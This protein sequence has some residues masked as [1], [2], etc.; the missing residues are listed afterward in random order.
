MRNSSTSVREQILQAIL[1]AITPVAT[2]WG[3][4]VWRSPTVALTREQCPALLLLP[5]SETLAERA[6]DRVT[7]ELTVRITVLVRGV[8][9]VTDNAPETL[10]DHLLCA[11][12]AALMG[13]VTVGG[14]ALGLRELESEW[15]LDDA[16]GV[17]YSLSTQYQIHYRTLVSD[18]RAQA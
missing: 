1:T 12:H 15:D 7:R 6:N 17:A 13:D 11:A 18:M 2:A 5:Q 9:V 8:A 4:S 16:D 10:A 3:A 14:L